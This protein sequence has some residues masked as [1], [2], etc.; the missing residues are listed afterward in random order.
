MRPAL[1][2]ACGADRYRSQAL[3]A[4]IKHTTCW[5][6]RRRQRLEGPR[7]HPQ[8]VLHLRK[9]LNKCATVSVA[10]EAQQARSVGVAVGIGHAMEEAEK[11]LIR[12]RFDEPEGDAVAQS[13]AS[14]S[15]APRGRN[16]NSASLRISR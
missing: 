10:Y 7:H 13:M 1:G 9:R 5:P 15:R 3:E 4:A 2:G 12:Q 16:F 8:I 6:R 11:A 14:R